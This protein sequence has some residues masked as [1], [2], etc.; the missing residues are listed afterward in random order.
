MQNR[1]YHHRRFLADNQLSPADL[2]EGIRLKIRIFDGVEGLLSDTFGEERQ[3]ME[4]H[5]LK[6]DLELVG[7]LHG[8]YFDADAPVP[9]D[10]D[11]AVLARLWERGERDD[12]S[13]SYLRSQGLTRELRG[14]M[15]IGRF[16]VVRQSRVRWVFGVEE[17]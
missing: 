15:Q 1:I 16:R 3:Q 2:T 12:L 14:D 7:D 17:W 4:L 10:P 9:E 6:I 5:L 13:R 8:F 11:E